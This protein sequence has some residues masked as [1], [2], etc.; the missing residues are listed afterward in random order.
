[1]PVQI[2]A[3]T[4][5]VVARTF[6]P[7]IVNPLWLQKH[8]IVDEVA[9]R[10][11]HCIYT[12][13]IA[14]IVTPDF[15]M[16]IIPERLQFAPTPQSAST[17]LNE[18]VVGRFVQTLPHTPYTA[19]G[20]NFFWRVTSAD[21]ERLEDLTRRLFYRNDVSYATEVDSID[22]LFGGY[23]LKPAMGGILKIEAQSQQAIDDA[24]FLGVTFN[25]HFDVTGDKA[26]EQVVGSLARWQELRD[27]SSRI[28]HSFLG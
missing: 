4:V 5:A 1:M 14:R 7:S 28:A 9:L 10:Q 6:N 24:Q 27:D 11:E 25:Y 23:F 2:D 22:T 8:G 15:E 19:V 16:V 12:P 13:Q 17:E 26:T 20:F 21:G 3:N 18:R